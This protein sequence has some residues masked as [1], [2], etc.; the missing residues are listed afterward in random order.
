MIGSAEPVDRMPWAA[1]TALT[2]RPE[3]LD[4]DARHRPA[5]QAAD[6]TGPSEEIGYLPPSRPARYRPAGNFHG[7][8]PPGP[9]GGQAP[10]HFHAEQPPGNPGFTP[11][12][13]SGG[14]E[15]PDDRYAFDTLQT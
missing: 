6:Y 4:P 12:R 8:T 15:H 14:G 13:Q 5:G 10:G 7:Y 9:S 2:G 3:A 1:L 11:P